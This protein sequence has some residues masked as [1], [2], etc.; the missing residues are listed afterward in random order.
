MASCSVCVETYNR[1]TRKEV[2]CA[3]CNF[4][5]CTLCTQRVLLDSANDPQ[6]MQCAHAWSIDFLVSNFT[7][8]FINGTL[9]K[10]R[11]NQ[12]FEREMAMMPATQPF[13][14]RE[15]Q[16]EALRKETKELL[17]Q[18]KTLQMRVLNMNTNSQDLN[19]KE[20]AKFTK[21]LKALKTQIKTL[22]GTSIGLN[23]KIFTLARENDRLLHPNMYDDRANIESEEKR[24]FVRRCP[25]DG[26]KGFLN[27]VWHCTL[28]DNW[29]CSHCHE[30]KGHN[31]NASHTCKPENV[32][33]AK[34]LAKDTKPCPKCS[35]MIH[36]ISG[37]SQ[38]FC[39]CCHTAFNWTTLQIDQGHIHNPH[40]FEMR[41]RMAGDAVA[42]MEA[43]GLMRRP[44]QFDIA[45]IRGMPDIALIYAIKNHVSAHI[46]RFIVWFIRYMTHMDRVVK[47]QYR[48]NNLSDNIDLRAKF[49]RNMI[50][51]IKFKK[52]VQMR[53][54]ARNKKREIEQVMSST[55]EVASEVARQ[56][57]SATSPDQAQAILKGLVNVA[58]Q[59][60]S[61]MSRISNK[62]GGVVPK[63]GVMKSGT[64]EN[65]DLEKRVLEDQHVLEL[66]R[67][68]VA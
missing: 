17:L 52:M 47:R 3:Y 31:K 56:L 62:Y 44:A 63:Y 14:E 34:L 50:D 66:L 13:V 15:I 65:C 16:I 51:E 40:Y 11:E 36:K 39:T 22:K 59:A 4:S 28:C 35:V 54:K 64:N 19:K 33:T 53:E 9:K 23:A 41:Q 24:Q 60:N 67:Q 45:C 5:A 10:H 21:D 38:M 18:Q 8:T 58:T 57:V 68:M 12:L 1:S 20:K 46:Y 26:C 6:C 29:T 2:V 7:K 43:A 61:G 25:A 42:A 32:E 55:Y 27:H 48:T 49:M 37:C 30:V